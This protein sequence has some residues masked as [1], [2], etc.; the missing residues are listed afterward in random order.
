MTSRGFRNSS[1]PSSAIRRCPL[2]FS[3]TAGEGFLHTLITRN[4]GSSS[5]ISPRSRRRPDSPG[6]PGVVDIAVPAMLGT[7][8][9]GWARVGIGESA[10][11]ARLT[12]VA[13]T[14]LW[15]ALGAILIGSVVAWVMGYRVTRQLYRL[16]E[17]IR[18]V[19]S[20]RSK[21]RSPAAGMDEV[22]SIARELNS[23]L[24][25][26]DEHEAALRRSE[27][28]SRSLLLNVHAAVVVHGP[29]GRIVK[30]NPMAQHLLGISGA[31]LRE[32]WLR[33][34]V[35]LHRR[36]WITAPGI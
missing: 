14:G 25:S 18:E 3:R 33:D 8:H 4:D 15:Y 12:D 7:Q 21:A 26:L 17:T 5:Q 6:P 22:S 10:A 32:V 2:R 34:P 9:V 35:A 36:G 30:A 23:M 11:S 1:R 27:D 13:R 20:G 31:D 16:Q 29:D 24:D 28:E 19:R